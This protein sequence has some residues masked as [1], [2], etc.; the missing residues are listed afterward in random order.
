[1][2]TVSFD[3]RGFTVRS[4]RIHVVGGRAEYALLDRPTWEARLSSLRGAGFNSVLVSV[5]WAFHEPRPGHFEFEGDHDLAGFLDAAGKAGL[6]VILRVGPN[7]GAPFGGG[8]LPGWLAEIEQDSGDRSMHREADPA[9][10]EAVSRW[11]TKLCGKITPFQPAESPGG[12]NPEEGPLLA[13]QI[14]H[15]W[16]CGNE[17]GANAYLGELVHMIRELGVTVPLLTANEF[18]QEIEGL[19]ETWCDSVGEPKLFSNTRQLH[20][21]QPG[22]P[23]IVVIRGA[24]KNPELLG[25][26]MLKVIA[27][28]GMP[29]VD[30]AVAGCHR[31]TMSPASSEQGSHP[32]VVPGSIIELSG[33]I[34]AGC[35][36]ALRI[37]RFGRA[38]GHVLADLDP[39][40]DSPIFEPGSQK[41]TLIPRRGS[42][43]EAI[44]LL[45]G[46]EDPRCDLQIV[47]RDGRRLDT[48][49]PSP[50]S[51]CLLNVDLGG[52]GRLNYSNVPLI[53][54]VADKLLVAYGV[55]GTKALIGIDGS[56][57]ELTVPEESAV[58]PAIHE[59]KGFVI[60]L[61]TATQAQ[62]L[63]D[64]EEGLLF[65]A[66]GMCLDDEI[67]PGREAVGV[68]RINNEGLLESIDVK[69][70]GNRSP[71]RKDL[72]WSTAALTHDVDGSSDR[73]SILEGPASL[74]SCDVRSGFGWYR[75]RFNSSTA[76][77][78][79]LHFPEGP[80]R[81]LVHQDGKCIAE[82]APSKDGGSN[83]ISMKVMKGANTLT[84]LAER[85]GG[86]AEGNCQIQAGGIHEPI[87]VVERLKGVR[88]SVRTNDAPIDLFSVRSFIP[89]VST[90]DSSST[91]ALIWTFTHRKK[92]AIRIDPGCIIS[93]TWVLNDVPVFRSEAGGTRT[94]R[95]DPR[96]LE[97]MK[98]GKNE[99]AFRPDPGKEDESNGM[100][101]SM[102]I[103]EVIDE[104][105][106]TPGS[107]SFST[108]T[109]PDGLI[110]EFKVLN[111]AK[112]RKMT[113]V[114]TWN[115]TEVGSRAKASLA[116]DISNM[117]RGVAFID[118]RELGLYDSSI[119][120]ELPVPE[121]ALHGGATIDVF[122]VHGSDPRTIK[123]V[124]ASQSS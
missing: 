71:A 88:S 43:G 12:G 70:H 54:F 62:M 118:G 82:M 105:G 53:D 109:I 31:R 99:L 3:G 85:V 106:A 76:E 66:S 48:T 10:F 32:S 121:G 42:A 81:L 36:S 87:E 98:S 16:S 80:H 5:P 39:V 56:D 78:Q 46:D 69:A 1:M 83:I 84:V 33:H 92:S 113:G 73:F 111:G 51:W 107:I 18:W 23:R 114:P 34:V 60:V 95:L 35:G 64:D 4:T 44:F 38:F 22:A 79:Q 45:S 25:P 112:R 7:V 119:M 41:C 17:E 116:L 108:C 103:Y 94:M 50:G 91:T 13:V 65:G 90:G 19:V 14:E 86:S 122:D 2:T 27:A 26:A 11:W 47:L 49:V 89:N 67:V 37:A 75:V 61:C 58:F 9:F 57:I 117:S 124:S 123:L 77:K 120:G 63:V 21:V 24:A 55:P 52:R 93:G 6:W 115:R 101:S 40:L 30:D 96:L 72:S 74:D 97:S 15:E 28:G 104:I 20:V 68:F 8:G 102:R 100:R 59:H 29:I 110:H